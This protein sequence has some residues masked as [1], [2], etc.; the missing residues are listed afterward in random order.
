KDTLKYTIAPL[1]TGAENYRSDIRFKSRGPGSP[2]QMTIT[3]IILIIVMV[4]IYSFMITRKGRQRVAVVLLGLL[5]SS[6]VAI[7]IRWLR[8]LMYPGVDL[9]RVSVPATALAKIHWSLELVKDLG[10][11]IS[12]AL[13]SV[14]FIYVFSACLFYEIILEM[15]RRVEKTRGKTY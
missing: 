14:S 6:A 8:G 1:K 5:V 4:A 3:G 11:M 15:L 13:F 9:S 12:L 7:Y 10:D 2:I